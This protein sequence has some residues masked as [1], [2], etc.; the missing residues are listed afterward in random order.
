LHF[1]SQENKEETTGLYAESKNAKSQAKHINSRA[2]T[3]PGEQNDSAY[4]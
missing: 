2:K 3:K 1:G 4:Q